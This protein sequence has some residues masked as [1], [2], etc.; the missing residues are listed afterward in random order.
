MPGILWTINFLKDQD[1][2]VTEIVIFQD[3]KRKLIL[4][5]NGKS[6]RG[7][8]TKQINIHY[9]FVANRIQKG[10]ISVEWCPTYD[11]TD[12]LFTKPNQG[13][14]LQNFRETI[15][16]VM[17]QPA[18]GLVNTKNTHWGA[19]WKYDDKRGFKTS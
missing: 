11:T 8:K 15:M 7:K 10:E 17:V 14:L 18:P 1:Y 2:G 16:G 12:D 9:V 19:D 13:S 5:K 4:E 3:K 6:S